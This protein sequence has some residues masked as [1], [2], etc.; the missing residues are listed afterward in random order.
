MNIEELNK[1]NKPR[2]MEEFLKCCG[3]SAWI[4]EMTRLRPFSDEADMLNKAEVVWAKTSE[5]DWLEAFSHHPKIGDLKSLEKKFASTKILASG[6][7]SAVTTASQSVLEALAAGNAEYE[8]KFGFIFIVC[9]TGKSAE[10]MLSMLL[11]RLLNNRDV[12]LKIAAAEQ[13]KITILR[14]KK[15]LS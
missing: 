13:Y 10:E 8:K 5:T 4:T 9:A 14:L 3:S 2:C 1:L 6:E 12:E 7:Q 15:I 11:S